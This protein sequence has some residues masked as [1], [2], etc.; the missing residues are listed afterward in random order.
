MNIQKTIRNIGEHFAHRKREYGTALA[1]AAMASTA[2]AAQVRVR[3]TELFKEDYRPTSRIEVLATRLPYSSDVYAVREACENVDFAKIR[4]RALPITVG[5]VSVGGA[6]QGSRLSIDLP[7]DY[8][9][10]HGE[11]GLALAVQGTPTDNSFA[12]STTHYFP[13][14]N[15][16]DGY[17]FVDT[18]RV[19]GDCL[20]SYNFGTETLKANPGLD[21]KIT[22]KVSAGIEASVSSTSGDVNVNYVAARATVSLP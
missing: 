22:D 16:M 14:T 4:Y 15:I 11:A 19:F 2:A 6:V 21:Y 8:V 12:K 9:D 7:Q 10:E 20:W 13:S 17:A 1:L 5:P 18:K 3:C